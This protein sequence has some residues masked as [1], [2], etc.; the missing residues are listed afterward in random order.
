MLYIK[1]EK[2][3]HN[4]IACNYELRSNH[5]SQS[6]IMAKRIILAV[7]SLILQL[8]LHLLYR[9]KEPVMLKSLHRTQLPPVVRETRHY[10]ATPGVRH[11]PDRPLI[12][13]N[14]ML[15]QPAF[16]VTSST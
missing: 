14:Q 7:I 16:I 11:V 13:S 2:K 9:G 5:L 15:P 1:L 4:L 6:L 8:S 3:P 10:V 12:A